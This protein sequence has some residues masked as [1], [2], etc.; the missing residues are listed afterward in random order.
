MQRLSF[1]IVS[2]PDHPMHGCIVECLGVITAIRAILVGQVHGDSNAILPAN[3]S[4]TV[5]LIW[6]NIAHT[7]PHDGPACARIVEGVEDGLATPKVMFHAVKEFADAIPRI[8]AFI[9]GQDITPSTQAILVRLLPHGQMQLS[10]VSIEDLAA[11]AVAARAL[12]ETSTPVFQLTV[13][14]QR[15]Y[16]YYGSPAAYLPEQAAANSWLSLRSLIRVMTN[17]PQVP[18]S[19]DQPC[20][21]T[22]VTSK[23]QGASFAMPRVQLD[24]PCVGSRVRLIDLVASAKFNGQCGIVLS[25]CQLDP[26]T[27]REVFEGDM[28][29][30]VTRWVVRINK[31]EK[32]GNKIKCLSASN[33]A[34][35]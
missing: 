20:V 29:D 16:S 4:S 33:L 1:A 7:T 3:P 35:I 22:F 13:N 12:A 24:V 2:N 25:K 21:F 17:A 28:H 5:H 31:G 11:L 26:T 30:E 15:G 27:W 9:A 10:V 19:H 18:M 14:A 32:D 23:N 8:R 6:P 34:L